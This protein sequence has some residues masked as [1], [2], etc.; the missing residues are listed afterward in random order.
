M[1]TLTLLLVVERDVTIANFVS[2]PFYD[3]VA[4]TGFD[5]KWQVPEALGEESGRCLSRDAAS[6]VAA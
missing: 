4:K 1:Q 6:Q 3:V 5:A 2:K